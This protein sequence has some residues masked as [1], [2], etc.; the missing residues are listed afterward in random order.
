MLRVSK[1]FSLSIVVLVA[2][3]CSA[4]GSNV[5]VRATAERPQSAQVGE[6]VELTLDSNVPRVA[7]LIEPFTYAAANVRSSDTGYQSPSPESI[8]GDV[9]GGL[10]NNMNNFPPS[11][12]QEQIG[13]GLAAQLTTALSKSNRVSILDRRFLA[14]APQDFSKLTDKDEVGP[15]LIRGTVTEFNEVADT[16]EKSNGL[17]VGVVGALVTVLGTIIDNQVLVYT[18]TGMTTAN[19]TI[20]SRE[21]V[22]K[23]MVTIDLEIVDAKRGRILEGF[24]VSGSFIS[25]SSVDGVSIFGIS[26]G[27]SDFAA[28]AIGQATRVAINDAVSK[29]GL[30]INKNYS[31]L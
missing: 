26:H 28:S 15:I 5:D 20:T 27:S 13:P 23:G 11:Y 12:G 17:N 14:S 30:V 9:I 29:V 22:R 6:S 18:G 31:R 25:K 7:V 3:G 16:S 1:I 24:Q 19:P 4:T 2:A 10:E 21:S 8:V